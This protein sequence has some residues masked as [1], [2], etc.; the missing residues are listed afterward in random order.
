MRF[1]SPATIEQLAKAAPAALSTTPHP[2][3]MPQYDMVPT[4]NV[5]RSFLDNGYGISRA[6]QVE[7]RDRYYG[8]DTGKHIICL[9]P[10]EAFNELVVGDYIPEIV[11]TG[12]HDG[13]SAIHMFMGIFRVICANG[14]ITGEK[15]ASYR[16]TH[17]KGA[18]QKALEAATEMLNLLP[19]LNT[20]IQ[21]MR[22]RELTPQEEHSLAL[23]ALKIRYPEHAPFAAEQLLHIRRQADASR[24][25]WTVL[26][27]IQ[28]NLLQGG[29][30]GVSASGRQLRVKP[31]ERISRD[32]EINRRLWNIAE[33][34]VA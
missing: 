19:N 34:L 27:R 14:M 10:L 31:I 13:S 16:I 1:T 12:C 2:N 3:L 21:R 5:L 20:G 29:Q 7:G 17:R 24:N 9:R 11:Y 22:E 15:W 26:N 23:D 4:A 25:L 6:Q 8:P 28:E 32:V 33:A 30:I 18:E